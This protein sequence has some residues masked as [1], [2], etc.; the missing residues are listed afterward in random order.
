[1]SPATVS[2]MASVLVAFT[3]RNTG[4]TSGSY[5][6]MVEVNGRSEYAK[7]LNLAPRSSQHIRFRLARSTP[8][9][10][11]VSVGD[12][13]SASFTVQADSSATGMNAPQAP[14]QPTEHAADDGMHP[15]LIALLVMAGVAFLTIVILLLAGVL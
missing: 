14:I 3:V 7:E 5:P 13:P 6:L 11:T 10:Y 1:M 12:G 2:P 8:G 9:T 15:L 4:G